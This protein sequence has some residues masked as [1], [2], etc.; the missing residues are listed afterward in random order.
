MK[1]SMMKLLFTAAIAAA[2][3]MLTPADAQR[4]RSQA[5]C[6]DFW[7]SY[8]F[9]RLSAGGI[10]TGE[11]CNVRNYNNGRWGSL[12][13]LI[14][15]V[16]CYSRRGFPCGNLE[17]A[18]YVQPS[19]ANVR[20][21]SVVNG[22]GIGEMVFN[23]AGRMVAAGGGNI[24]N[25]NGGQ[26]VAAGGGN[27]VAAGGGNMVAAGGGNLVGNDGASILPAATARLLS[28]LRPP[29]NM[30]GGGYRLQQAGQWVGLGSASVP[31]LRG[32]D[33]K[34]VNIADKLQV[35]EVPVMPKQGGGQN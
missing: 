22:K 13:E 3:L 1:Q 28:D 11:H 25:A 31:R 19:G 20:V 12:T 2:G 4:Y 8:A 14:G 27:M 10:A 15:L 26:M 17:L 24:F 18:Q 35:I 30:Q 6:G 5:R 21:I 16:E 33:D 9:M 7:V 29:A 34:A 32:D 23:G